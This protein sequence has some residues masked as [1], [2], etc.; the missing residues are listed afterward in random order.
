VKKLA[1]VINGHGKKGLLDSY[2][3]ERRP[4]AFMSVERSKVHMGTHGAIGEILQPN[5]SMVDANCAEGCRLRE[6][7]HKH[8]QSHDGENKDL[9]VEM[10][11]HY[12]SPINIPDKESAPE[13]VWEPS[14]YAPTTLPGVRA[15]HVFLNDGTPIFD[16]CGKDYTL[17]EFHDKSDRGSSFLA[18]A[19]KQFSVP[20]KHLIL[21]GE[22]NA[23]RIWQRPLVLVRPDSHV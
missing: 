12:K 22:N 11:F 16:L 8:Y 9:G 14:G 2:E 18:E 10:G 6:E 15:P 20:L 19:A 21:T 1:A 4:V 3:L 17:V 23:K 13:P 5:P 7:I